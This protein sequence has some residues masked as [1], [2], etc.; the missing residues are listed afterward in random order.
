MPDKCRFINYARNTF[1]VTDD[2]TGEMSSA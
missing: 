2:S 1:G